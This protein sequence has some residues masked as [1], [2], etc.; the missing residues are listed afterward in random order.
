MSCICDAT[1]PN[2]LKLLTFQSKAEVH[3][4]QCNHKQIRVH[5][6]MYVQERRHKSWSGK[7]YSWQGVYMYM[8]IQEQIKHSIIATVAM[9][10]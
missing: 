7:A 9:G 10:I 5:V 2:K 3:V 8:Y 4:V 6:Q 1:T